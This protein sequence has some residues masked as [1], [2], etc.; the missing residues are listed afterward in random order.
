[1]KP[2]FTQR[3]PWAQARIWRS[4]RSTYEV[5]QA[6][7]RLKANGAPYL[8]DVLGNVGPQHSPPSTSGHLTNALPGLSWHQWDE[9][10]DCFWLLNN[11]AEW[12]TKRTIQIPVTAPATS[13]A[14]LNAGKSGGV[15]GYHVYA[16]EAVQA[17]L[18]SAGLSWGWDWPHVQLRTFGSPHDVYPWKVIDTKMCSKFGTTEVS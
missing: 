16:E 15:N 11:Q 17:G 5:Q 6:M 9:A 10:I 8:S 7:E 12:S 18:L 14:A 13:G 2:F 4:T 3:T 1:M